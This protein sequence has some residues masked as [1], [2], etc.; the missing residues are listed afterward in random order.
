GSWQARSG[1]RPSGTSPTE[2]PRSTWTTEPCWFCAD[3][4]VVDCRPARSTSLAR[5]NL[6]LTRFPHRLRS[7]RT[8]LARSD[9]ARS[10]AIDLNHGARHEAGAVGRQE[11]DH[12]AD[13]LRP[14]HAPER[15]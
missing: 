10:S 5:Q 7:A 3:D 4:C 12:L 11:D 15:H 1:A 13:L 2:P 6:T 14:R 8:R 9:A